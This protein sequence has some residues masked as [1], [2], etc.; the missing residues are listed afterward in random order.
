[1]KKIGAAFLTGMIFAVAAFGAHA[2]T[3]IPA[4]YTKTCPHMGGTIQVRYNATCPD[5]LKKCEV[6][7]GF[8]V[9]M[10]TTRTCPTP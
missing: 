1:M 5:P 9:W 3:Q 4:G 7:P 8:F 2:A 6:F 10:K